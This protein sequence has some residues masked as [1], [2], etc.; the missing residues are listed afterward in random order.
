MG[1]HIIDRLRNLEFEQDVS[2]ADCYGGV[3]MGSADPIDA[4]DGDGHGQAP[5]GRDDD[6]VRVVSF[7][8][9]EGD[10]GDNAIAQDSRAVEEAQL[11]IDA[12][13]SCFNRL[14]GGRVLP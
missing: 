8:L 1:K 10:I 7:G 14:Q 4:V 12:A 13:H 9:L 11:F 3:D 6:P 2:E 5:S